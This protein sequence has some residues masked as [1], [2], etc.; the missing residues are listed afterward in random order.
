MKI[1]GKAAA[2]ALAATI[3]AHPT[4]ACWTGIEQEAAKLA[5]LN[6]MMMVSALRCRNGAD[7]FL[8]EY[9]QFV[10]LYNPVLGSHN[11][12]M[13]SHFARIDGSRAADAAMDRFVIGIANNY[14]A[15]HESMGCSE[16]RQ[17]AVTLSEKEHSAASLL[18]LADAHVEAIPLP[19]GTCRVAIASR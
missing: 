13:R 3:V 11:A 12:T 19:G 10:R 16:L 7:N 14:G 15:G 1:S 4:Q 8:S 6:M 18:S 5:N 9:N 2:L 17:L